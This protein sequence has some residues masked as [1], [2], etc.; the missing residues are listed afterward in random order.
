M[1]DGQRKLDLDVRRRD[2]LVADK[3]DQ[4][5]GENVG[6]V[7]NRRYVESADYLTTGVYV[8]EPRTVLA[9]AGLRF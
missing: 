4:R 6:N 8:G 7:L 2:E 9:A 3:G 5:R 1:N